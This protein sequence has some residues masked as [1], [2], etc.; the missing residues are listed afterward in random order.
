M[1]SSFSIFPTYYN[2]TNAVVNAKVIKVGVMLEATRQTF[3]LQPL[4]SLL[5]THNDSN[6]NTL[7]VMMTRANICGTLSLHRLLTALY[8]NSWNRLLLLVPHCTHSEDKSHS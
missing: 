3:L 5:K 2:N 4:K 1:S 8:N 7:W 6:H